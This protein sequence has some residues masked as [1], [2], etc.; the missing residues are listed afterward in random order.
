MRSEALSGCCTRIVPF[1][2]LED[3]GAAGAYSALRLAGM[4]FAAPAWETC[5]TA[6]RSEFI[7]QSGLKHRKCDSAQA[8]STHCVK[9]ILMTSAKL[10]L[11]LLGVARGFAVPNPLEHKLASVVPTT[12]AY[13]Y[14]TLLQAFGKDPLCIIHSFEN[15]AQ[16]PNNSHT[17]IIQRQRPVC[18]RPRTAAPRARPRTSTSPSYARSSASMQASQTSSPAAHPSC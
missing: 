14:L 2:C 9:R 17:R 15:T 13:R 7:N 12:D 16:I 8:K 18:P 10:W 3:P 5:S 1:R 4:G 11:D 6:A